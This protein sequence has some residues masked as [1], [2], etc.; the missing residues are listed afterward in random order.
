M[1]MYVTWFY[2]H[3]GAIAFFAE[4]LRTTNRF[5]QAIARYDSS[6]NELPIFLGTMIHEQE[7]NIDE[8]VRHR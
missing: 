8:E 4:S 5:L 2:I 7:R 1:R 3:R 6:L